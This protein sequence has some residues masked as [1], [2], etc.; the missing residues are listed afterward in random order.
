MNVSC[1]TSLLWWQPL[2]W[3]PMISA[4]GICILCKPLLWENITGCHFQDEVTRRLA[5]VL[6]V[7]PCFLTCS[8]WGKPCCELTRGEACRARDL[9]LTNSQ[10]G[11]EDG[12]S[13]VSELGSGSFPQGDLEVMTAPAAILITAWWE[14]LLQ[15]HQLIRFLAHGNHEINV[16]WVKPLSLGVTY[17][18]IDNLHNRTFLL[19][20]AILMCM[21]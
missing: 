11:P 19:T 8:L 4:S 20:L 2:R 3:P 17:T 9:C 12:S 13:H 14:T 16:Y 18:T 15:R 5:S 7:L 1:A 10:Q 21:K 6:S